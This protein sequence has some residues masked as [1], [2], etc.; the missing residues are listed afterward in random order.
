MSVRVFL[1]F[2]FS[3]PTQLLYD[4]PTS[5]YN[6]QMTP[7]QVSQFISTYG[8]PPPPNKY[9]PR[10]A[11]LTSVNR[12]DGTAYS[13]PGSIMSTPRGM[14][15]GRRQ[16]STGRDIEGGEYDANSQE[17][18]RSSRVEDAVDTSNPSR[19]AKRSS[20]KR[21]VEFEG[22]DETD[23]D[24]QLVSPVSLCLALSL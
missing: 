1:S 21:T 2:S 6:Q 23:P 7:Q 22:D 13:G 10:R 17:P 8:L 24:L 18:I 16:E 14:R 19:K 12:F 4:D 11:Q 3:Y 15:I 20:R 9:S 5:V